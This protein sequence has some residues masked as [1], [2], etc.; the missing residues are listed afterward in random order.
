MK[1]VSKEERGVVLLQQAL[2]S[3]QS[4]DR[5]A[6]LDVLDA[7][8]CH[9][10]ATEDNITVLISQ[11]GHKTLIQTPMFVI[12]CWRPILK[13]LADTL[14]PRKLAEVIDMHNPIPKRV[15][16]L[17]IFPTQMT[18]VQN[19]AA[20]NLKRYVGECDDPT[21]RSFL[22]FCTGADV[23]FG[24]RIKVEFIQTSDFQC[25]TQGHTCGCQLML[26]INYQNY[27]DLRNDFD[28]ILGSLGNGHC[29][30]QT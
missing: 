20:R 23:L 3:L 29:V 7:H 1:Y 13:T 16:V 28:L 5:D 18:A 8:D 12:K 26:P 11:L 10:L 15:K 30:N 25:R 22:R 24:Q 19:S 14:C 9:H 17:L 6:L 4:V 21:L 2:S 27:P